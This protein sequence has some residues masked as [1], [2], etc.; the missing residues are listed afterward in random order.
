VRRIGLIAL[1][2]LA[3]ASAIASTATAATITGNVTPV[4]VAPEVEVCIVEAHPSERCT[5]P[6]QTGAY[7]IGGLG[8]GGYR[9]EFI[10]S[11]R[12]HY[13]VQY[14]D[15]K[16]SVQEATVI[17]LPTSEA[18][19][20]EV[21]A[22]LELGGAIEGRVTAM[23]GGLPLS[24]VE[25]CVLE[26]GNRVSDG[27]TDTD[28]AGAYK[29][30]GLPMGTYKVGFWGQGKSAEYAPRYYEEAATIAQATPIPVA[31]GATVTEVDAA[32]AKGAKVQGTVLAAPGGAPLE[33]ISVCLFAAAVAT[34]AQCGYS[35]AGGAYSLLGIP[36][37]SYQVGFSLG[38]AEIGGE[39][40]SSEDDGYL[41]QWWDAVSTREAAATLT[42]SGPQVASGIDAVLSTPSA[43]APQPV[44]GVVSSP[45][46]A[47]PPTVAVPTRKK[48]T[49]KQKGA[50]CGKPKRKQKVKGKVRCVKPTK[51]KKKSS[52]KTKAKK[53]NGR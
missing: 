46:V 49:K 25:V 30:G 27:C 17:S 39:A 38:P 35:G 41:T 23:S 2:L 24:E 40:R 48:T 8:P 7:A 19:K 20:E 52:K 50:S 11:Y 13:L 31:T 22:E 29:L 34:P 6:G 51:G 3:A 18:K 32:M 9:I 12:S 33:G 37:G 28:E 21:D 14:Y 53:R 42:L 15:D 45:L 16:R 44:L 47:A 43:P 36:P 26:A 4:G 10:P 5:S 1:L